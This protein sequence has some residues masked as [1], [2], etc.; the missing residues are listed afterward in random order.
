MFDGKKFKEGKQGR[1]D[2]KD[3]DPES[4]RAMLTVMYSDTIAE[5]QGMS[6]T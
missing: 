6:T 3:T 1:V 4:L 5:E 2:I